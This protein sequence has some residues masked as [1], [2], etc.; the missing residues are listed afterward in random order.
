MDFLIFR[1]EPH[2]LKHHPGHVL[3]IVLCIFPEDIP[4][5]PYIATLGLS[6]TMLDTAPHPVIPARL[7]TIQP[8]FRVNL[9]LYLDPQF[10]LVRLEP[11]WSLE[12]IV[13]LSCVKLAPASTIEP[14]FE[15]TVD[16]KLDLLHDQS[17]IT[18][19][20]DQ[21]STAAKADE[22]PTNPDSKQDP[23][24]PEAAARAG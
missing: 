14:G 13:A 7:V 9:T 16:R 22:R 2:R 24:H 1:Y 15:T 6:F 19:G 4:I 23:S 11:L 20:C 17:V 8:I 12:Q 21:G 18:E 5:D 3:D 10:R